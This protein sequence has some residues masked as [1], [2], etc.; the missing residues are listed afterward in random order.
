M[1]E[2]EMRKGPFYVGEVKYKTEIETLVLNN[3]AFPWVL[4]YP[5]T[6]TNSQ[7]Y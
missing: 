2:I 7:R 5:V 6:L 4:K 1:K 3:M